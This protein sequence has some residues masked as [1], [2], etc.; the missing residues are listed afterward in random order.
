MCG[1]GGRLDAHHVIRVQTMKRHGLPAE[2]I[3]HPLAG[4]PACRTCHARHHAFVARIPRRLV[5]PGTV[6]FLASHGLGAAFD[7]D[8]PGGES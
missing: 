7:R 6:A 3:Y 1:A 5:P 4:I 8:Y 2:V